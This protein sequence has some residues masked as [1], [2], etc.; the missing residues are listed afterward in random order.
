MRFE[1]VTDANDFLES[2]DLAIP[3]LYHAQFV[4]LDL[5]RRVPRLTLPRLYRDSRYA[6]YRYRFTPRTQ[7]R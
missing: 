3:L 4:V 2:G 7:S 1:R 5:R 6:L